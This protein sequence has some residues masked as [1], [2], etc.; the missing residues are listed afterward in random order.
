M[1]VLYRP[2][3]L[4][5]TSSNIP[6]WMIDSIYRSGS[7]EKRHACQSIDPI[8]YRILSFLISLSLS[9]SFCS[10]YRAFMKVIWKFREPIS[11]RNGLVYGKG[12]SNRTLAFLLLDLTDIPSSSSS[13]SSSCYHHHRL[14]RVSVQSGWMNFFKDESLVRSNTWNSTVLVGFSFVRSFDPPE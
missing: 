5:R 8:T 1:H 4:F 10:L 9:L 3:Y 13:S 14:Q 2:T 12:R 11:P 7:E 6:R